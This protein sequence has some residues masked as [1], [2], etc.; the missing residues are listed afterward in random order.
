[1]TIE[2]TLT[3]DVAGTNCQFGTLT[4]DGHPFTCDTLEDTVREIIGAPVESWKIPGETAI[5]RGRYLVKWTW[6]NR[7]QKFTPQVM[8]V[9]GFAGIRIHAGNT[10]KDTE[11]CILVGHGRGDDRILNSGD[12]RDRLYELVQLWVGNDDVWLTIQ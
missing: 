10:D 9:P 4:C 5:P 2:L 12:T 1:M 8:D 7:F 3:R 11:G 6:S